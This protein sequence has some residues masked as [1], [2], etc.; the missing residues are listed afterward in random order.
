V[1]SEI[2]R[3]RLEIKG[4][5][6]TGK[7]SYHCDYDE[8]FSKTLTTATALFFTARAV[9]KALFNFLRTMITGPPLPRSAAASLSMRLTSMK[10]A[11]KSARAAASPTRS[12][13]TSQARGAPQLAN[14]RWP[15]P[16]YELQ[17]RHHSE[18]L[19]NLQSPISSQQFLIHNSDQPF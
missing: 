18:S 12:P 5:R 7:T 11:G 9:I 10:I 14:N 6:Q 4:R 2:L 8:R 3:H 15:H 13:I 1:P 16:V 17:I 19:R